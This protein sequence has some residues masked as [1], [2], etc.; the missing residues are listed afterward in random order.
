MKRSR[1]LLLYGIVF[2]GAVLITAGVALLLTSVNQ[3]QNEARM[4]PL[5]V[6]DIAEDEL[7]PAVWGQ[8]FPVQY[9]MF[10]RTQENYG[11]TPYGGSE[12]YSKLERYPAMIRLW[13]GYAFSKDHNEERGHFYMM[14]DQKNT[15]RVVIKEQPGAC[16]NCHSA[17]VIPLVAQMGWEQFNHTPY[18]ELKDKLV[19]GSSCADCH[20]P[21]TMELRVTRQAFKNAMQLRGIDLSKA[22]RQEMR[23]YVCAQCHVEYYFKGDNKVLTFP[24]EQGLSIDNIE[25]YYNKYGFK[26]WDHAESGAPML[27]MQHPEFEMYSSGIHAQS[28]VACADCHMPYTRVGSVKVSDHWLRSPLV[29]ISASCQTC[30]N[31]DEKA[32]YDSVVGIQNKTA[33]LLRQSEEALL[34]AID[35]IV[36]AKNAGATDEQLVTARDLHRSAQ[37]RWDFVSSENSTGFHSPQEAA[38]V[39]ADC[40]DIARQA[41]IA[42][43]SVTPATTQT[44]SVDGTG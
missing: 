17:D 19:H 21:K 5:K 10:M 2:F 15:Q 26:D 44:T 23:T 42:A 34:D 22:T 28:G 40:L 13:A 11:S 27:K 25:A 38:R 3:R 29:N 30:H 33:E 4:S 12:K 31:R 43:L 7:D 8:N 14:L 6:V 24:W 41:Q 9:E 32:L 39:L 36:T 20:D 37:M 16:I 1:Q 18:N 35:A